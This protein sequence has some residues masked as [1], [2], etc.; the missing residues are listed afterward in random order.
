MA[1]N[2]RSFLSSTCFTAL[3]SFL[4]AFPAFAL[5]S[6]A[7]ADANSGT[8]AWSAPGLSF[9]FVI[10]QQKLRQRSLVPSGFTRLC[11]RLHFQARPGWRQ[12]S[13]SAVRILLT[14]G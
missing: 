2:R 14:R 3:G 5:E 7:D 10:S 1:F 12:P 8:I 11:L 6:P 13:R 4:P 9:E